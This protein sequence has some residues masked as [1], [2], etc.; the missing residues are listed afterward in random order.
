MNTRTAF[1]DETVSRPKSIYRTAGRESAYLPAASEIHHA[2]QLARP[3]SYARLKRALDVTLAGAM[4]VAVLPFM[5][6]AGLIVRLTSR[7]PA[8][9]VQTRL[10]RGGAPFRIYKLRTMI[11]NCE[12]L[13]GPRW[14]VPGDPRVTTVGA[15]L[16]AT[17]LDELPQLWNVIRGD[18]SLIGPRPERPE[19]IERLEQD[20]PD[21]GD[22]HAVRPGITGLAQVQLP[23]DTDVSNVADKLVL[24][25]AYIHHLSPRLDLQIFVCTALRMVG[26][27]PN[28]LRT[29]LQRSIP[30]D[31]A[32]GKAIQRY[33]GQ[34]RTA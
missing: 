29:I 12:S 31:F 16:R 25:K 27:R 24:D 18:M 5:L 8:I 30:A 10:G 14:A 32:P 17:H 22:R 3:D 15:I 34:R 13:T 1:R 20:M 2:P 11:D 21:Y 28:H 26:L 23:P 19:I 4:L 9:Y 7:G 33:S 6:L